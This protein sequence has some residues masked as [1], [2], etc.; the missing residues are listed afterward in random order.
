ARACAVSDGADFDVCASGDSNVGFER[1]CT[2]EPDQKPCW[3]VSDLD[4]WN[5]ILARNCIELREH[6]WG[7]I[8]LKG[9]QWPEQKPEWKD[10]LRASLLIHLLLRQHRCVTHIFLDMSVTTIER[11]V[12]WH[13]MKNGA[14]GV[15]RLECQPCFLDLYGLVNDTN[16]GVFLDHLARNRSVKSLNVQEYLVIARQGN[17]LA[18][19]VRNHVTLQEIEVRGPYDFRPS[20]LLAAA[21]QSQSLRS[22]TVQDCLL[23]AEDIRA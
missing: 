2:W 5:R 8:S 22:L 18:D 13:A 11:Y 23:D 4:L 20:A 16:A 17:A 14:G 7:E 21:V 19:V 15:E 9:Y 12:V 1:S 3:I 10:M 6:K